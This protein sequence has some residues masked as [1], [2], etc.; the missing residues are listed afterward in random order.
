M[1]KKDLLALKQFTKRETDK[2]AIFEWEQRDVWLHQHDC[3]ELAY[4]TEGTA[5]QTLDGNTIPLKKGAYFIIDH[6]SIHNYTQCENMKLIN[7]LF[8]ADIIDASLVNCIS[9]DELMRVCMIRFYKQYT[10]FSP[11]N[12]VFYDDDGKILRILMDIMEEFGNRSMGYREIY[13][14]KL[15][16]ILIL[17]M[18]KVVQEQ[19]EFPIAQLTDNTII[20]EAIRYF[21]ANYQKKALLSSFC[22]KNHYNA[23][24]ISRRFKQETGL[25]AS[26]YLHKIRIKRSCN[27]L[28]GSNLTIR[29]IALQAG[30]EDVKFFNKIFKQTIGITPGEYRKTSRK[31]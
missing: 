2:L 8:L 6:G 16:E 15:M 19:D 12:H 21:E 3:F 26:E 10:G 29:E 18:R 11:V 1:K 28:A 24:Y 9:F 20:R 4:I 14:G 31:V 22:E 27:L 5:I 17:T 30:Y 23:Q 25:T 7:C 13:R